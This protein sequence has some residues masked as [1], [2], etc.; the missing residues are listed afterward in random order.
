[1]LL[2]YHTKNNTRNMDDNNWKSH[3]KRKRSIHARPLPRT[4]NSLYSYIS[5]LKNVARRTNSPHSPVYVRKYAMEMAYIN[6]PPHQG[7]AAKSFHKYIYRTL[8]IIDARNNP[9]L[10]LRIEGK[11]PNNNW[12]Q[13]S[14]HIQKA[15]IPESFRSVWYAVIHDII[16]TNQRLYKIALVNND[17]CNTCGNTDTLLHRITECGNG[18]NIWD[19]TQNR[20]ATMIKT[21]RQTIPT[22][23]TIRSDLKLNSLRKH[24]AILWQLAHLVYYRTQNNPHNTLQDYVNF[25]R[26]ALWKAQ[27]Q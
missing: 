9:N 10:G 13:I 14:N 15:R 5:A 21:S 1:M 27:T 20:T 11:N 7:K 6:P 26:R 18:S 16:P 25:L 4:S 23:W 22:E 2:R 17:R 8:R 19:W 12:L 24:K 3:S